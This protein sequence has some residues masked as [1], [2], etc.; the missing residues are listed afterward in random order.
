MPRFSDHALEVLN[1]RLEVLVDGVPVDLADG[2]VPLLSF[3]EVMEHMFLRPNGD[4]ERFNDLGEFEFT[5]DVPVGHLALPNS[6]GPSVLDV[7]AA[8]SGMVAEVTV[9]V[10]NRFHPF[11][12]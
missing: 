10:T 7:V 3:Q 12:Q 5:M 11:Q 6:E 4:L 2:S 9:Q 8:P 1:G